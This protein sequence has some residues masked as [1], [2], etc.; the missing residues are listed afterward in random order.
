[1]THQKLF[2][3]AVLFIIARAWL[4]ACDRVV[5]KNGGPGYDETDAIE[6]DHP[7]GQ[8]RRDSQ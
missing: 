3:L 7:Q 5:G 6:T 2:A 8:A 4:A 1:M